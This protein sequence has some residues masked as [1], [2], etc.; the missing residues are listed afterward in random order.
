MNEKILENIY[1]SKRNLIVEG[2]MSTGKTKNIGYKLVDKIIEQKENIFILDT[3]EEYLKKYY[4]RLQE[5]NYNIVILN[6][7]KL[8]QSEGWNPLTNAYNLYKEG[9]KDDAI[10]YI[11]KVANELFYE[12]SS[13]ADTFWI[14]SANDFFKGLTL[15]LFE[16]ASPEEINFNSINSLIN[17]AEATTQE[18]YLE[19]YFR[20]KS[21]NDIASICASG[22][23]FS[24]IETRGGIVATA[25][26]K[27]SYLTSKQGLNNL[28]NK[29]T[30]NYKDIITNKTAIFFINKEDNTQESPLISIFIQELY[31]TL[32]INNHKK[33]NFILDNLDT[34]DNINNFK[35][36]LSSSIPNNIK[37]YLFT[38]DKKDI[39][40]KYTTYINKITDYIEITTKNINININNEIIELENNQSEE[41]PNNINITYPTPKEQTI[42]IFN[43]KKFILKNF[44][45]ISNEYKNYI[46][47]EAN[48]DK[49]KEINEKISTSPQG[50]AVKE[51]SAKFYLVKEN[52][53]IK[54]NF[55]IFTQDDNWIT[56][57]RK[58]YKDTVYTNFIFDKLEKIGYEYIS[59]YIPNDN[60]ILLNIIKDNYEVIKEEKTVQ[61][62]FTFRK[63]TIKI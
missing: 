53:E 29:T 33:Y 12:K 25:K 38:R 23:V 61:D 13:N 22:T 42:K 43:L 37:F 54:D 31:E 20:T 24:P 15:A 18:N 49:Y 46:I 19:E 60:E 9:N 55:V 5:N 44:R 14:N 3:R 4:Q 1:N 36:T 17:E 7:K 34:I 59:C 41:T 39:E 30:F 48:Y 56:L 26:Q 52:D 27:T 2:V 58:Q 47:E 11:E 6:L 51:G 63:I 16:D 35:G 10:T 40:T 50:L 8:N 28:L 45:A 32:I 57:S 62:E 21:S